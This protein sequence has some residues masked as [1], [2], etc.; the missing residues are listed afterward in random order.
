MG[1]ITS[2]IRRKIPSLLVLLFSF[3]LGYYLSYFNNKTLQ[4]DTIS[5][6]ENYIVEKEFSK[7][8]YERGEVYG[9]YVKTGNKKEK[10]QSL[11]PNPYTAYKI[12]EVLSITQFG[13]ETIIA[14][15]PFKVSLMDDSIWVVT[16]TG[17]PSRKGGY[18]YM[19]LNR[20]SG[21]VIACDLDK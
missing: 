7:E 10:P 15:Y 6:E 16:G 12:A 19:E 4:R 17:D 18:L 13:E 1:R 3:C 20:N 9:V 21:T 5:M 8:A 14:Q 2:V 11:V